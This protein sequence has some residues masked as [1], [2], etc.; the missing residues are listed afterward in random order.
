MQD[1]THELGLILKCGTLYT[2]VMKEDE[3]CDAEERQ[4]SLAVDQEAS[5]D[6]VVADT[7]SESPRE[8]SPTYSLSPGSSG[9]EV[10]DGALPASPHVEK[11]MKD[12]VFRTT[13]TPQSKIAAKSS[14]NLLASMCYVS[15]TY[16]H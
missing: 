8:L 7:S 15:T 14:E 6:S 12:Q 4:E 2:Y 5:G 10:L 3:V 16:I 1:S 11:L 9:G 13:S